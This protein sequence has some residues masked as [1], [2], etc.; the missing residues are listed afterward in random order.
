MSDLR[1]RLEELLQRH[2]K[3]PADAEQAA[4]AAEALALYIR[5][6][7][8]VEQ[9]L[10][11]GDV[12]SES[13]PHSTDE[14]RFKGMSLHAAAAEVLEEANVPLHVRELG[15]RI[16]AGGWTHKVS[17]NPRAD[18]INY[19]LAARLPR[20]PQTFVRV[21]PNT[22]ALREW[23][24]TEKKQARPR[25]GLFG[26]PAKPSARDIGDHP[27]LAATASTWRSS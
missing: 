19:Q 8:Q 23:R 21:A 15:K 3:T 9:V 14:G 18:Q 7:A 24:Q 11:L 20:H 5:L 6:E 22:F 27:D 17:K 10:R 1:E 4:R 2:P 12:K 16:K 25:L 26:G 13:H